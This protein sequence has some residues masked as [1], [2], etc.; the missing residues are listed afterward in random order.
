M[1][2]VILLVLALALL[3]LACWCAPSRRLGALHG[4]IGILV[5]LVASWLW[6]AAVSHALVV[7]AG[8]LAALPMPI[9]V[10]V[11]F[12]MFWGPPSVLAAVVVVVLGRRRHS[13]R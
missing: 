3:A 9:R 1:H 8:P 5:L 13:A 4:L 10:V 12:L 7:I 6:I 2:A 11:A